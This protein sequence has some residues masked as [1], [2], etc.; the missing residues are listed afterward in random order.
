M[1]QIG[2]EK[3]MVVQLLRKFPVFFMGPRG[4]L[5]CSQDSTIGLCP[6]PDESILQLPSYYL[7]S[8]QMLSS[9][10]FL[11]LPSDLFPSDFLTNFVCISHLSHTCYMTHPSHPH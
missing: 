7:R 5:L 8:I 4:S 1:E 9:H 10:L 3:L 6:E 2:F 11:S